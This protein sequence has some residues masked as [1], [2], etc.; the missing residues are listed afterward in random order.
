MR[1]SVYY[2]LLF[3]AALACSF[4]AFAQPVKLSGKVRDNS[5][6]QA[7]Q[8]VS[9]TIKG[10]S[11]G[12]YTDGSGN[13]EL[14]VPRLPV[15]LIISSIGFETQEYT[16][17]DAASIDI[18]FV[19]A[20]TLGQEVVVSASRTPERILE[21]PVTIE[22][23][24][25]AAI[26]NAPA[27][28][29]YDVLANI[30]GVD[31]V[32]SSLTF[33]TPSTRGFT[34][35]GNLRFNQLID[36]MDNQAPGLNFAVGGI[37]GVSELDVES[38]ELLP[39]ASSALYGPGGMNGTLLINS[40]NPFR[41]NGLSVQIKQGIMHIDDNERD[42]SPYYNWNFRYAKTIGQKFAFKIST[43]FI[44]ARDWLAQDY[45]NYLR[46]GTVGN[47]IGGT[48][49]SDPN[50]DGVNVYGDET[51][52]DI[53]AVFAGVAEQAPFLA[54][55][56]S[57]LSG[58]AVNV[59][60]TGY[61]EREVV[62]P[63][64]VN[65]RGSGALHYKLTST[66]E[67]S[68]AAYI[69][70]GN[71]V[72][73][74]SDRYSLKNLRIAQ[75]KLELNNPNW[76]LRA[77]TTQEDAG[78]SF[79]AT[80]TTRLLNEVWKPSGG[81]T[82]WFAQYGQAYLA[83]KLTGVAD[84]TAHSAARAAADVGRPAPG[85]DEFRQIFDQVRS[86]PISKNGGL[87]LDKTD[88]YNVEG[89]YNLSQFTNG[90]ADILVGA[91]FKKYVLNSE[92][93][94]FADSAG[95]IGINEFGAYVQASRQIADRL[96]LTLSGRYDKNENFEGRFT[97]RAT[98]LF[99]ITENNNLRLSYQ[100]AYRFPSTQQQWI[101]LTV[102][103]GVKLI[104]GVQELKDFYRFSS[105]PVYSLGSVQMR[106]PKVTTFDVLKPE[107]VR[108]YELGYKGLV[109][110]NRLLIDVYGYRG[111]YTDFIV[112]DFVVQ[113]KTG[114]PSGLSDPANQQIYSVP[115]NSGTKV[116]TYGFGLGIDYRLPRNFVLSG[117][118]ASDVLGDIPVGIASFNAPKYRSNLAFAN[119]AFG[120]QNRLGF[121]IVYK[122]QEA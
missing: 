12:T 97:P 29:F 37:I 64:T 14:T 72:Y 58:Q 65:F 112:R 84:A 122:W 68:L 6:Q 4:N 86:K 9:I 42:P 5:D 82:G 31:L 16:A 71:T 25:S 104:G 47:V 66:T 49:Q 106:D 46:L 15:T 17:N 34:G 33:K 2:S 114:N 54:P 99:K 61:L 57:S 90:F 69:G 7:V 43:D 102:A 22:R 19:P 50:Y 91:N 10:A 32:T 76:F 85:S 18:N 41:S 120:F 108:S 77:Y 81:S 110:N 26:R 74:G 60:R 28:S 105:N 59:S 35:S 116:K 113:S 83:A 1:K 21:S 80:V 51:T 62:D 38:I 98:A 23:I 67:A 109:A 100:T 24:S 96:K 111:S 73:T 36:G 40:K 20:S 75:Y 3:L 101:N 70:T 27:A 79:N 89:Q 115:S 45:R 13:F 118:F 55:F 63:N 95:T 87:F 107:S 103:G 48:R 53:R 93:T 117:N 56:I 44:H 78:E 88:L 30:K 119:S 39:G 121:N 94:L 92:G 11:G 52:A 8:A